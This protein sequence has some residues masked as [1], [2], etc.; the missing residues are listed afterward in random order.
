MKLKCQMYKE[1]FSLEDCQKIL[2]G[3]FV[4]IEIAQQ[5]FKIEPKTTMTKEVCRHVNQ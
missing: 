5:S 1:S 3:F 2:K 4:K